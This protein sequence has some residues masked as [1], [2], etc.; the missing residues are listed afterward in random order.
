MDLLEDIRKLTLEN[1][2]KLLAAIRAAK[3]RAANHRPEAPRPVEKARQS[4]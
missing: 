3:K 1:R 4:D 2:K